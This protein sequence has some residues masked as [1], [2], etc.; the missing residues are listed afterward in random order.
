MSMSTEVCCRWLMLGLAGLMLGGLAPV[1]SA[2]A[3]AVGFYCRG[4]GSALG[5]TLQS[6]TELRYEPPS[7]GH[8][9]SL[10]VDTPAYAVRVE[11]GL[12]RQALR[13]S[14]RVQA[15]ALVR[16]LDF[17]S[18]SYELDASGPEPTYIVRYFAGDRLVRTVTLAARGPFIDTDNLLIALR[19]RS[20]AAAASFNTDL[21]LWNK[22]LR[23]PAAFSLVDGASLS[24]E[25][26]VPAAIRSRLPNLIIW[27]I[28][29]TGL[30][31]WFYGYSVYVAF[32]RDAAR[33]LV[34]TWSTDRAW[35]DCL[36]VELFQPSQIGSNSLSRP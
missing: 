34:G 20:G 24:T 16:L 6:D 26:S 5:G 4:T 7:T 15:P 12:D 19:D 8:P 10:A 22:G 23:L 18:R 11:I 27:K 29:L 31:G 17:T 28:N 21:V 2:Q 14:C 13:G 9:G 36:V 33:S 30:A 1:S 25:T 32:S 3:E 35:G